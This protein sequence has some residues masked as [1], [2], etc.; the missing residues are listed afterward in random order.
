MIAVAF[1]PVRERSRRLANR[2]VYGKR[3]TPYEVLSDFAE[4]VAGAYSV[5]DV[6]PRTAQMLAEGTGAVR[7]DVW[8]LRRLGARGCRLVATATAESLPLAKDGSFVVPGASRAFPVRYDAE[9]LGALSVQKA[10][11]EQIT[12]TDEKL[13]TDVASQAGLVLSNARLIEDLRASRQRYVSRSGRGPANGWNKTCTPALTAAGRP[14]GEAELSRRY[15][16][17]RIPNRPTR[18]SPSSKPRPPTRWR[19][20]VIWPGGSIRRCWPIRGWSAALRAGAD[21]SAVPVSVD[22]DG[23]GRF[24]QDTEAAVYFAME[25]LQNVAEYAS[26]SIVQVDLSEGNGSLMFR[27]RD[28]GV[29]FDPRPPAPSWAPGYPGHGR[30]AGRARRQAHGHLDSGHGT[31]IEG[32]LPIGRRATLDAP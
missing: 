1:Q 9:L 23:V 22:A 11:G 27:V 24:P 29:G 2:L 3:A 30:P 16:R 5:E 7:A 10:T 17:A 4:R 6:L 15:S 25:A 28:D 8:L 19:P 18:Y 13:L 21:Q 12:S 26:A 31:L 14:G 32:T 20:C